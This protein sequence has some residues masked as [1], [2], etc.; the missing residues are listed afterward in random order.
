[1]DR[2]KEERIGKMILCKREIEG[3]RLENEEGF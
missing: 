1:M 3:I 2:S